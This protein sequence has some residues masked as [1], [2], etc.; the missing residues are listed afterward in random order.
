MKIWYQSAIN[1]AAHPNYEQAL[2]TIAGSVCREDTQVLVRGREAEFGL[3]LLAPDVIRSAI[4]YHLVVTPIFVRAVLA[5]ETAG[6]DAFVVGTYS[7]PILPE[8]RS[9]STIPIVTMP[10]ATLLAGCMCAPK[11]GIVT[12]NSLCVPYMEK[13][14]ALHKMQE[15]VSGIHVIPGESGEHE[16]DADFASPARHIDAFVAACREAI[17]AGAQVLIPAEGVLSALVVS[18]GLR[19]VDGVPVMDSVGT[20]ILFAELAVSLKQKTGLAHSLAAYTPPSQESRKILM[21]W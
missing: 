8:L 9:L 6:A 15:R 20:S 1:F 10:E 3:Q 13:S 2:N 18:A 12:L 11:S 17:A 14:V 16:L 19:E 4:V 21:K 5:A 7:E